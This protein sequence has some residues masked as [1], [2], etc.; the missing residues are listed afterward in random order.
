MES[1]SKPNFKCYI[2]NKL[3]STKYI[4]GHNQSFQHPEKKYEYKIDNDCENEC[5]IDNDFETQ[6]ENYFI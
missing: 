2:C 4:Q 1:C 3:Y 5:N 6:P